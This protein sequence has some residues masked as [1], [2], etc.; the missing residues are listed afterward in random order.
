MVGSVC[1][2]RKVPSINLSWEEVKERVMEGGRV[3]Q[4]KLGRAFAQRRRIMEADWW[5]RR[6][7]AMCSR[8][9]QRVRVS[10]SLSVMRASEMRPGCVPMYEPRNSW[11]EGSTRRRPREAHS[12]STSGGGTPAPTHIAHFLLGWRVT[13]ELDEERD[14]A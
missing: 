12:A 11:Q 10:R 6:V 4:R 1:N 3:R 5:A 9:E 8:P 2:S 13:P 7:V 14:I